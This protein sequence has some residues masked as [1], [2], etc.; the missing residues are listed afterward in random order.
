MPF[1]Y[2]EEPALE[3]SSFEYI[4]APPA[5]ERDP[6]S[7]TI[8]AG[9]SRLSRARGEAARSLRDDV[10]RGV[11]LTTALPL[12]AL[13]GGKSMLGIEP[14]VPGQK[15]LGNRMDRQG[16]AGAM[17]SASEDS[18]IL[19]G[20]RKVGEMAVPAVEALNP[21]ARAALA[22]PG[23]RQ[24]AKG[25]SKAAGET[26]GQL[27]AAP[28]SVLLG[29]LGQAGVLAGNIGRAVS[30]GFSADMAAGT[31]AQ[32]AELEAK[33]A[34]PNTTLAQKTEAAVNL[35]ISA[36][37]TAGALGHALPRAQ[38]VPPV[39]PEP[40]IR[41]A[42]PSIV[43][44]ET[45]PG[46]ASIEA[47]PV[48]EAPRV[49]PITEPPPESRAGLGEESPVIQKPEMGSGDAVVEPSPQV[50]PE[51]PVPA[52]EP[53]GAEVPPIIPD[54]PPV[55]PDASPT[56]IN[57]ATIDTE[58]AARGEP[59]ADPVQR[60]GWDRAIDEAKQAE[61]RDPN[62]AGN[63][64]SEL[65]AKV[66]PIEDWEHA[67]LVR[68]KTALNNEFNDATPERRD[69]IS[70]E[71]LRIE[72]VSKHGG[73]ATETARALNIRK[74]ALDA[75][76]SLA[77]LELQK[78]EDNGGRRLTEPERA[79]LEKLAKEHADAVA[80][81]DAL[82]ARLDAAPALAEVDAARAAA[83]TIHPSIL[84][85][86][87]RIVT[88]LEA[89]GDAAMMRIRE[90][91]RTTASGVDPTL[92]SDAAIWGAGKLARKGL[93]FA[94]WSAEM[95][96]D[97]GDW[98]KPHLQGIWEGS[99]KLV[100]EAATSAAPAVRKATQ[101]IRSAGDAIENAKAKVSAKASRSDELH[102]PVR[103]L[104]R[105]IVERDKLT[106]TVRDREAV[107]D[108]VH[109]FLKT[110][111]PEMTRLQA[112]D[113]ISGR[114]KFS[115][116]DQTEAARVVR[117]IAEQ[118]RLV[119]HQI[120]VEAGR[121]LP[122]TGPQR[123]TMSDQARREQAK[124]NELKRKYGVEATDPVAQLASSLAARKTYVRNRIADLRSEIAA[125]ERNVKTRTPG[126]TDAELDSM[127]K[128]LEEVV[129][130][131]NDVFGPREPTDE[132]RVQIA[133]KAA[134]RSADNWERRLAEAKKGNFDTGAKRAK[135]V[136]SPELEAIRARRD[137]AR[138]TAMEL[139]AIATRKT[140][141]EI[142]LSSLKSRLRLKEARML[143]QIARGDFSKPAKKPAPKLDREATDAL[144]RVQE[145][146]KKWAKAREDDQWNRL[147]TAERIW[148]LT[149]KGINTA[150]SIITSFDDSAVGRQGGF[151]T[152]AGPFRASNAFKAHLRAAMSEKAMFAEE[153]ALRRRTN[154]ENGTY[155]TA[156]LEF[157]DL[158]G[159][160]TKME[161]QIRASWADAVP[162]V[163]MSQRAFTTYLNV[164]R[165]DVFDSLVKLYPKDGPMTDAELQALGDF[166]NTATG[167]GRIP[168]IENS[169]AR[170]AALSGFLFAPR[171][172]ASRFQMVL[173]QPLWGGT[174]RTRKIIAREYAKYAASQL[175]I[176]GL[177]IAAGGTVASNYYSSEAGKLKFGKMRVDPSAG[178][179]AALT[180][181]LRLGTGKTMN[182]KG[183]MKS[184]YGDEVKY[185]QTD[186]NDIVS[187][188]VRQKLAPTPGAVAE[189]LSGRDAIGKPVTKAQAVR[190]LLIPAP[191][192]GKDIYEAAKEEGMGSA[193]AAAILSFFGEGVNTYDDKANF[194]PK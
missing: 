139:K 190:H 25:A 168:G 33:I 187:R 90:K 167:K 104:V 77:S 165:A 189:I 131:H 161:E 113:A 150:R 132:Q 162:G 158:A 47:P 184:I 58:R 107:I 79:E 154:F 23:V 16:V 92:I 48:A 18:P 116:P 155:K 118:T 39:I 181:L 193:G 57:D 146:E 106:G 141:D 182:A 110:L 64:V 74:M 8:G 102:A 99:Q 128:E 134:E 24:V 114:G 43:P 95:T 138:D 75:D 127:R 100:D 83:S 12:A 180:F 144:H 101:A 137:L 21:I 157:S 112:M 56:A 109:E 73:A 49:D 46:E 80:R 6:S 66:R 22:I 78:R 183:E 26:A 7:A 2:I 145:V 148:P 61:T 172:Y 17:F 51:A 136:T 70:D 171:L 103:Q 4:D 153:E 63:L 3:K 120:D 89:A 166:V 140:P 122:R 97:L 96:A 19:V 52:V 20:A 34:D 54:A 117:D 13:A 135:P 111:D 40:V 123:D 50:T 164:L 69:A 174:M 93:D 156:K 68:R 194:K 71:L 170:L 82:Q 98:V 124:L 86:A 149:K 31:L 42:P 177:V 81:A 147:K 173:G 27:A 163:K 119:G 87:E 88:R 159:T 191:L 85:A 175:I 76:F 44:R 84:S 151:L 59:P 38:E 152:K 108:E 53:P 125:R 1:E 45:V 142:A 185:G 91:L 9:A 133:T 35:G 10:S 176:R 130:E 188:F 121:P 32:K 60:R 129:N 29:G 105:A 169:G 28:G 67:L 11:G 160:P 14:V 143:D 178:L 37:M 5:P 65:E 94:K 41:D 186:W 36:G 72:N 62:S 115:L 30:S 15:P 179:N 55:T 126:P 192:L